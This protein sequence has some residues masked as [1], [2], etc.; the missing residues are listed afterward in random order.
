MLELPLQYS[1][2]C[3]SVCH[4]N[5]NIETTT[6]I[7]FYMIMLIKLF[8]QCYLCL[9][10]LC[11]FHAS[12]LLLI[13]VDLHWILFSNSILFTLPLGV[14][15]FVVVHGNFLCLK[16]NFW[17]G[18]HVCGARIIPRNWLVV[19]DNFDSKVKEWIVATLIIG[20]DS[21]NVT[22]LSEWEIDASMVLLTNESITTALQ[23]LSFRKVKL[24][25]EDVMVL[26]DSNEDIIQVVDIVGTSIYPFQSPCSL[27]ST[28]STQT[29]PY[30]DPPYRP[31]YLSIAEQHPCSKKPPV[32]SM[33]S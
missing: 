15:G 24:E 28:S 16:F 6:T 21:S 33:P 27:T 11:L 3:L 26:T 32:C 20:A 9:Q 12:F 25:V 7:Q 10:F 18:T 19:R 17:N 23:K 4:V 8:C 2:I 13:L 29:T 14:D 1:K 31:L 22:G 30:N 5:S